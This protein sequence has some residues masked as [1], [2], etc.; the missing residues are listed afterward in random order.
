MLSIALARDR[1]VV[2]GLVRCLDHAWQQFDHGAETP[3]DTMPKK[4]RINQPI[5]TASWARIEKHYA[6]A[7][8]GAQMADLLARL[9]S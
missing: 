1:S 5:E 3:N 8:V 9:V 7:S 4:A 2:C 6:L